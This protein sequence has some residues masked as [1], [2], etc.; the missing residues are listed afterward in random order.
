MPVAAKRICT[1][2]GCGKAVLV[3]KES[4]PR[5]DRHPYSKAWSDSEAERKARKA[6]VHRLPIDKRI[7]STHWYRL[8]TM[9]LAR[10]PVCK[11]CGRAASSHVDHVIPRQDGGS[12]AFDN[13]QGLCA[14]CHTRKTA[15]EIAARRKAGRVLTDISTGQS[16]GKGG[17]NL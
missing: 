8:R 2:P 17:S 10:D 16:T 6:G 15:R 4:G 12:D 5:C 3:T 11:A 13:L 7:H 1:Y 9:I 14:S